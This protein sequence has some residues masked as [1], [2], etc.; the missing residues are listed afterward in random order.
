[1]NIYRLLG[2][3]LKHGLVIDLSFKLCPQV[4]YCGSTSR[5]V[6]CGTDVGKSDGFGDFSCLKICGK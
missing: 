5:D 3:F 1:M 6:L 4:C 2:T